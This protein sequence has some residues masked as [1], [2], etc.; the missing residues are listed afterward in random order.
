[1][2]A[3]QFAKLG[4]FHI[5][6]DNGQ[7]YLDAHL[8]ADMA[9]TV[10]LPATGDAYLQ[11]QTA[12]ARAPA[13]QR[14][15][16]GDLQWTSR[17]VEARGSIESSYRTSLFSSEYGRDYYRGYVDSIGVPGVQFAEPVQVAVTAPPPNPSRALAITAASVAGASLVVSIAATSLAVTAKHEFEATDLQRP[18]E[19]ARQRYD[20]DRAVAIAAGAVALGT[21]IA[22]YWLWPRTTTTIAAASSG[23][24]G[25]AISLLSRW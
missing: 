14:I 10:V 22:A 3:G 23:Q 5:E 9:T 19:A 20:R 18:A 13:G 12:E 4:H 17:P 25:Y 8:A 6:L 11:T 16:L 15:A 7:R 24:G 21:G 2:L 1:V